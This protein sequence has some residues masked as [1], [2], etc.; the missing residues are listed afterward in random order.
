MNVIPPGLSRQFSLDTHMAVHSGRPGLCNRPRRVLRRPDHCALLAGASRPGHGNLAIAVEP[1][2][3]CLLL[4]GSHGDRLFPQSGVRGHLRPHRR[5]QPDASTLHGGDSRHSAI[6][7]RPELS[8][9]RDAGDGLPVPE[10]TGGRRAGIDHPHLHGTG[11]EH[12]LQLLL[13]PEVDSA[14]IERGVVDL[15]FRQMAALLSTGTSVRDHRTDLEFDRLRCRRVVFPD[16]LRN[17]RSRQSA[18]SACPD[19]DLT[20]RLRPATAIPTRCFGDSSP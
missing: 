19:S 14:R 11:L 1:A 17:V 2:A 5:V 12:G 4:A 10:Q 7:S 9:G 3:I 20:C 16:G 8:A 13:V 6:D 18:I 15:S